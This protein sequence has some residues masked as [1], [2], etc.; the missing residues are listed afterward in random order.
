MEQ[1]IMVQN[2]REL[3]YETAE[4]EITA[5][6]SDAGT[7]TVSVAELIWELRIDSNLIEEILEEQDD[8]FYSRM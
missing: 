4:K 1:E 2:V 7:R 5:Y 8:E 3:D 6:L